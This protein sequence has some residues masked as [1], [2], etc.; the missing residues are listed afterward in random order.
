MKVGLDSLRTLRYSMS[1]G[2]KYKYSRV[3]LS[4][5][6]IH[7]RKSYSPVFLPNSPPSLRPFSSTMPPRHDQP[8]GNPL[9]QG[10]WTESGVGNSYGSPQTQ[11]PASS[12]SSGNSSGVMA[13]PGGQWNPGQTI[14]GAL[15]L[16]TPVGQLVLLFARR[17][18]SDFNVVVAAS[19]QPM[20]RIYTG[21]QQWTVISDAAGRAIARIGWNG[22]N[23]PIIERAGQPAPSLRYG[24]AS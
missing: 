7:Q 1:T 24:P 14:Y 9:L 18:P 15:P 12:G 13:G 19:R 17:N 23:L 22:S 4:F 5:Y 16:G 6:T 20:Y 8:H 21:G 3:S 2:G 11:S 10:G